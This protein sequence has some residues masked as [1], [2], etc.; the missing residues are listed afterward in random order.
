MYMYVTF[1]VWF[2]LVW[3]VAVRK[4]TTKIVYFIVVLCVCVCVIMVVV[5]STLVTCRPFYLQKVHSQI[6]AY[7][8]G[9]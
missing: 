1:V 7:E 6:V 8:Y 3:L 4:M 9:Q 5:V 2:G